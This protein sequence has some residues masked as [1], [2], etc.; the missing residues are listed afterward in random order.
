MQVT[1]VKVNRYSYVGKEDGVVH[2]GCRFDVLMPVDEDNDT[3]GYDTKRFSTDY[4]KFDSLV[5]LYKANK[6]LEL[7]LQFVAKSDGSYYAKAKKIG[8]IEL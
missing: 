4:S 8:N 5:G 6:P 1:L 2:D 7:D 3:I